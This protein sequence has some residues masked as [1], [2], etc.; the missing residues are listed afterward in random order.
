M[1][2]MI[3]KQSSRATIEEKRSRFIG[4]GMPC[5][6]L[7]QF[8]AALSALAEEFPTATHI[9]YAYRIREGDTLRMRAYD[10]NEP[11]GTAGRPILNHLTGHELMNSVIFVVRYFGGIKLG[12]GGL[13]RSYGACAGATIQAGEI[14]PLVIRQEVTIQLPYDQQN[15]VENLLAQI[16]AQILERTYTDRITMRLAVPCT[17]LARLAH[18]NLNLDN[19]SG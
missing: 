15:N 9:T 19:L 12:A 10:A 11:S 17:Q 4:V 14:I 13:A 16:D 8:S 5:S 18:L 1:G 6:S 7:T 2:E 3:F